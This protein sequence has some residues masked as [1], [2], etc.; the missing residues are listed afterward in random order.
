MQA[1]MSRGRHQDRERDRTEADVPRIDERIMQR[2]IRGGR[3]GVQKCDFVTDWE[4]RDEN[5]WIAKQVTR[6]PYLTRFPTHACSP[7]A[8]YH[9]PQC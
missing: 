1:A 3:R 6:L 9:S 5:S 8:A 2:G 7:N 4:E